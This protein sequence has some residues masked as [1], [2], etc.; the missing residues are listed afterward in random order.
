[1][2]KYSRREF[3]VRSASAAGMLALGSNA[4]RAQAVA[5]E[6]A[7]DMTIA[8]WNGPKD[9][10]A[11]Q[12]Q[13][14]AVKLT[15]KAIDGLGGMKRFVSKGSVVWIKPNIAWEYKPEYAAN[16]NPDV[17]ATLVRLCLDAGRR[18]KSRSAT[19][20]AKSRPRRTS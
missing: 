7:A 17:V 18:R 20:P 8:R 13:E 2:N 11:Q 4:L 12:F 5:A 9:L 3:V 1:M 16:T 14:A 10:N 19:T 15:E 6:K